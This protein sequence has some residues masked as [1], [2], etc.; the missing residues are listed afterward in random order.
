MRRMGDQA[1]QTQM[2]M[3]HRQHHLEA[4]VIALA[5]DP[6]RQMRDEQGSAGAAAQAFKLVARHCHQRLTAEAQAH[7]RLHC[8]QLAAF[9]G[10]AARAGGEVVMRAELDLGAGVVRR[11]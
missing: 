9:A 1:R 6:G 7:Q 10:R 4:G 3:R 11:A 8:I 2:I 5:A